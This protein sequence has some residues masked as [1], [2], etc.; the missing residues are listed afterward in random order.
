MLL[1]PVSCLN[2][3]VS[4]LSLCLFGQSLFFNAE[5]SST[6]NVSFASCH[7][8]DAQFSDH[9]PRPLVRQVI[10]NPNKTPRLLNLNIGPFFYNGRAITLQNQSFWPLF[11]K[12]EIDT[13]PKA[14]EKLGGAEFVANALSEFVKSIRS[15]EAKWDFFQEGKI[16][17]ADE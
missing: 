13:N 6:K 14:L 10:A 5:M 7:A 15:E 12:R 11:N 4:N 1:F 3:F 8:P 2:N 17:L 9:R 16:S